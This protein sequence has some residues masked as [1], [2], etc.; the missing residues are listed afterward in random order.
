MNPEVMTSVAEGVGF[1]KVDS[2]PVG[3]PEA[4]ISASEWNAVKSAA[5]EM[6]EVFGVDDP[7]AAGTIVEILSRGLVNVQKATRFIVRDDFVPAHPLDWL[8][9]SGNGTRT[10]RVASL[11]G[12]G[13]GVAEIHGTAAGDGSFLEYTDPLTFGG[14]E[15]N[16][17][18]SRDRQL[19]LA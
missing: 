4:E 9:F 5:A 15:V 19:E 8:S 14:E 17:V 11:L 1:D 6:V 7:P 3:N 18:R 13:F 10:D 16:R 12:E 2:R